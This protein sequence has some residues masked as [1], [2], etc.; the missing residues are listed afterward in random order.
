MP[1]A[2]IKLQDYQNNLINF[3]HQ[4]ILQGNMNHSIYYSCVFNSE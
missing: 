1:L 3:W 4:S 2:N